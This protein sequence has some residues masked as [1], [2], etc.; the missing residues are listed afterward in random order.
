MHTRAFGGRSAVLAIVCALLLGA[1]SSIPLNP[2]DADAH[3]AISQK[4]AFDTCDAPTKATMQTWWSSSP[5]WGIGIYFGGANR[6]CPQSHLNAAWVTY[7][8]TQG[9]GGS[10]RLLPI[11]FG[12]QM[13]N[14][15]CQQEK[16]Y[17][18]YISLN[19]TT[20]YDQG[21]DE[22]LAAF[23]AAYGLGL[24]L[25][26]APIFYDLEAY[27][28]GTGNLTTCKNAAKAFINGWD[29]FLQAGPAAQLA[30]VY[31][32][33]CGSFINGLHSVANPPDLVWFANWDLDPSTSNATCIASTNWANTQRHKQY[34]ANHDI[35]YGGVK[36]HIDEDCSNGRVYFATDILDS[37][38]PCL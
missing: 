7:V 5:F 26:D 11:W 6:G 19:A 31:G 24:D 21:Q 2:R 33:D 17:S 18:T 38:S 28:N 13:P 15:A 25:T 29:A 4:K 32:S 1:L 34:R 12:R 14:P 23:S 30:G 22:A 3:S 36:I 37:T 9:Q 27:G 16:L 35:T 10:W 20:A 8:Q